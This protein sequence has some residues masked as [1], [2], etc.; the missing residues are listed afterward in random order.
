L[1]R[2]AAE[3]QTHA[4]LFIED[5]RK[6]RLDERLGWG[7]G[8]T[9]WWYYASP[10]T[11]VMR[12]IGMEILELCVSHTDPL[13]RYA[14]MT[15]IEAAGHAFFTTTSKVA[16][17]LEKRTGQEYRYFGRYHLAREAAHEAEVG[18]VFEDAA[19]SEPLL[20]QARSIVARIFELFD[21]QFNHLHVYAR[22]ACQRREPRRAA[23]DAAAPLCHATPAPRR[24]GGR[25]TGRSAEL[26]RAIEER[27]RATDEHPFFRWMRDEDGVPAAQK[28]RRFTPLWVPDVMGYKDLNRYALRYREPVGAQ[29]RAINR[30]AENLSSHHQ[31][32]MR[33]WAGL[34]MDRVL[35]WNA[36]DA[37]KF[38]G[39]GSHTDLA[40]RNMATFV[41]LAFTHPRPALRFWLMTALEATGDAF[42]H[43]TRLLAERAEQETGGRLDYLANRHQLSHT[44]PSPNEE[45]SW[46]DFEQEDLTASERDTALG[47][48]HTAFDAIL[49]QYTLSLDLATK[50]V[51]MIS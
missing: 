7:A 11:E 23:E 41:K 1:N 2:Q 35:G 28:L 22:A 33:D 49:A 46:V 8:E 36:G 17:E 20:A 18:P 9:L 27:R 39:L 48:I 19:P 51:F 34:G 50:N 43:N 44:E 21:E 24:A 32:F 37:L 29:E 38:C 13:V 15:S 5:W 10:E 14:L 3:D 25:M 12:R 26:R 30:W 16:T 42:F 31:L 45:A 47:L 4:R 6:L 40:R